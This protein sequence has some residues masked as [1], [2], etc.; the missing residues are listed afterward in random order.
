[1]VSAEKVENVV[2][3]PQKPVIKVKRSA[4]G[5]NVWREVNGMRNPMSK[6]PNKL[7]AKVPRGTANAKVF[8]KIPRKYLDRAPATAPMAIPK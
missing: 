1:M 4:S 2:K 3:L 5:K 8:N 6:L 7:A